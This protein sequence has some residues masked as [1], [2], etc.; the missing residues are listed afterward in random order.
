MGVG[1]SAVLTPSGRLLRRSATPG[2]LSAVFAAQ[3][4]L[5]HACWLL[6]YTV[7]GSVGAAFGMA[8]A[9]VALAGLSLIGVSVAL[10]AWPATDPAELSHLHPDLPPQHPHLREGGPSTAPT[11]HVHPFVIDDLHPHWPRAGM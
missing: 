8:P 11:A 6:T 5:S 9:L 2:D 10:K 1:Y 4:A 7:A 3:F